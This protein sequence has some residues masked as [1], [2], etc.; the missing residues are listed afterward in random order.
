MRHKR[1][2]PLR[3][4]K[5]SRIR[6]NYDYSLFND[7][8]MGGESAAV[9]VDYDHGICGSKIYRKERSTFIESH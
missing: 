6:R 4:T 3:Y 5:K 1:K 9:G 7:C 8:R 2:L